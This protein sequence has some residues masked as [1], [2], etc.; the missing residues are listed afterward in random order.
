MEKS[1]IFKISKDIERAGDLFEMARES[2]NITIKVIPKSLSYK[3]LVEYYEIFVQLATSLMYLEGYKTLSHISLIKFL[4]KY[5]EFSRDQIRI[6]DDMRKFRHGTVYYGRKES[7]NFYI[8]HEKE[9]KEIINK[10]LNLV[11]KKLKEVK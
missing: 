3:L 4:F 9:I 6:L 11:G 10:L 1:D 2:L 8:N 7:G 5:N